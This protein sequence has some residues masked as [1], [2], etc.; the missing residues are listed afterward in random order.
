MDKKTPFLTKKHHSLHFD[1][2]LYSIFF[3]GDFHIL[4]TL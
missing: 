2:V 3:T 4:E 1:L